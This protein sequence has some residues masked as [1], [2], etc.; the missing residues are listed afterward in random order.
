MKN[1]R[2]F[3]RLFFLLE[4]RFLLLF[5]LLEGRFF[6]LEGRFFSGELVEGRFLKSW[7][8][9]GFFRLSFTLEQTRLFPGVEGSPF[10]EVRSGV[11]SISRVTAW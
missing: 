7:W 1:V 6:L 9:V 8:K 2:L 10:S 3:G 11:G 5:F 4:G